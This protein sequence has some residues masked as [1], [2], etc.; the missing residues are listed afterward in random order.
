MFSA[1]KIYLNELNMLNAFIGYYSQNL[2]GFILSQIQDVII[3]RKTHYGSR[4]IAL[5]LSLLRANIAAR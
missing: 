2:T 3:L 4:M 1:V 5:Q